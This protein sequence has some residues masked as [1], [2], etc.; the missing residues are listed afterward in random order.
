MQWMRLIA[1][2]LRTYGRKIAAMRVET[3]IWHELTETEISYFA[4]MNCGN[5]SRADFLLMW[6]ELTHFIGIDRV[7][8]TEIA[9]DVVFHIVVSYPIDASETAN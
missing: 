4:E 9:G 7:T 5:L 6:R 2:D 3:L 8:F 1:G